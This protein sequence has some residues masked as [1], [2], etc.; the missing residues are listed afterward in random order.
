M[1]LAGFSTEDAAAAVGVSRA[2]GYPVVRSIWWGDAAR[3]VR[4]P[5]PVPRPQGRRLSSAVREEIAHLHRLGRTL[6]E[7]AGRWG[8]TSPRSA[9]SFAATPAAAGTGP[10]R[11]S[12]WL[13][14]GPGGAHKQ[15]SSR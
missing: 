7:I 6:G 2:I 9:A 15:A 4:D 14:S 10:R 5:P 1:L 11:P 8:S 12:R 13:M 3:Q